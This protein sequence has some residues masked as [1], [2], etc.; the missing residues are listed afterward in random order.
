MSGR[1]LDL[2]KP[3]SRKWYNILSY[4]DVKV[5]GHF[6]GFNKGIFFDSLKINK[7]KSELNVD[8][9]KSSI[10]QNRD[11]FNINKSFK[12]IKYD[13]VTSDK[14]YGSLINVAKYFDNITIPDDSYPL[15]VN[16]DFNTRYV[17]FT[18]PKSVPNNMNG[19]LS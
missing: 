2:L 3:S 19:L 1:K 6:S 11:T 13:N 12:S 7:N 14:S 5:M 4:G 18:F 17:H 8:F 16:V 10:S 15:S 9:N